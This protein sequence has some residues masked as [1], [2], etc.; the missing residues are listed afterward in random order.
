MMAVLLLALLAQADP[1]KTLADPAA[2]ARDDARKTAREAFLARPDLPSLV[3]ARFLEKGDGKP[4]PELDAFLAKHW[5]APFSSEDAHK[6]ALAALLPVAAKH[7]AFPLFALAHVAA[8]GDKAAAEAAKLGFAKEG[9]RWGR[10]EHHVLHVLCAGFA[11]PAYIPAEAERAA[12]T[13]TSFAPRYVAA[14]LDI[15]KTISA[16]AGFE[17]L[18]KALPGVAGTG[19]PAATVEHLKALAEGVRAAAQCASCKAGK[20]TCDRCDG[21]KRA[22]LTCFVCKGLGW[23]QKGEEANRLVKCVNC[24]G[25]KVFKNAGCALCKQTGVLECVICLGK[26]WRDNFKGCKACQAC[27]TCKGRR[28]V[29]TPCATCGGKGRTGPIVLGIP[30]ILCEGCK[31]Q[32]LLKGTC[33]DCQESGLAACAACGS[34]VRDGKSPARPKVEDVYTTAPCGSCAGKGFPLAGLALPCDACHGLGLKVTPT[35]DPAKL[36]R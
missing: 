13:S 30:T 12:R 25:A 3:A 29:E 26:G 21:K 36:L 23:M 24:R 9:E 27:G 10:R 18:H 19:V 22:D 28:T 7:E 4:A 33:K 31:G 34:G 15:Q 11:K 16:N 1:F 2:R 32:A 35:A 20:A 14:L 8:L 5:A 6:A 17:A